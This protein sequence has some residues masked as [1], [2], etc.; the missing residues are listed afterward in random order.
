MKKCFCCFLFLTLFSLVSFAA[1]Y[2]HFGFN[3]S[4]T[5][6]DGGTSHAIGG[7]FAAIGDYSDAF[8]IYAA[9][10][11]SG[12]VTNRDSF[13]T[14]DLKKLGVK[15]FESKFF[16]VP[17]RIG[18]PF[19]VRIGGGTQLQIIPALAFDLQFF[20]CKFRQVLFVYDTPYKVNYDMS[21]WGY[22]LGISA[23]VGMQHR[24]GK[25]YLRYGIDVDFPFMTMILYKAKF[26][27]AVSGNMDDSSVTTIMDALSV[28][29]SPYVSVGFR[30]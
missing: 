16:A 15:D 18:Y 27:G 6:S 13:L 3:Y 4:P 9:I 14:D 24:L 8:K 22:S 2:L 29:L 19:L 1:D 7:H 26:S 21:G 25:V 28:T 12:D 30:L 17:L 23:N 20:K 5:I 10:G 11:F